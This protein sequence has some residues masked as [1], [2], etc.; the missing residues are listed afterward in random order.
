MSTAKRQ[1]IQIYADVLRAIHFSSRTANRVVMYRVEQLAG[2]THPRLKATMSEL[3]QADFIDE[4]SHVTERG[5]DF[6]NDVSSKVE[7]VMLKYG[8]WN[9]RFVD[10]RGPQVTLLTREQETNLPDS[11]QPDGFRS[12]P[13]RNAILLGQ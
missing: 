9:P 1:R 12:S 10:H 4:V 8:F 2:L 13:P 6:L 7:P 3:R 11:V 5:Y